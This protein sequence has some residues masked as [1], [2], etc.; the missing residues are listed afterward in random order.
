MNKK[1]GIIFASVCLIFSLAAAVYMIFPKL[2]KCE[3]EKDPDLDGERIE[4]S[5]SNF[6]QMN[7]KPEILQIKDP[8]A[9]D[10]DNVFTKHKA[11]NVSLAIIED[12]YVTGHYE[13][14]YKTLKTKAPMTK[15][16]K[17]RIAS[18]SKIVTTMTAMTLY[19]RGELDLDRDIGDYFGFRIRGYQGHIPITTKMLMS[20]TS[21]LADDKDLERGEALKTVIRKSKSEVPPYVFRYANINIGLVGAE[22][23]MIT[24]KHFQDYAQEALFAPMGLDCG[25]DAAN[26]KDTSDFANLYHRSGALALSADE[27][28]KPRRRRKIGEG[29]LGPFG[30][31]MCSSTELAEVVTVL[32]NNGKYEGREILSEDAVKQMETPVADVGLGFQSC[33]GLRKNEIF[34]REIYYHNGCAYG[35]CSLLAYDKQSRSGVVIITSGTAISQNNG[36]YTACYDAAE[37]VFSEFGVK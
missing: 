3:P 19:D 22:V 8:L 34:D 11:I 20:H 25:Y 13:Y 1:P 26:I 30:N 37:R 2:E 24:E 15:N 27:Q 35:V 14:G 18:L 23:E 33:L 16:T 28:V 21:S 4:V 12:G 7:Q 36:I 32:I 10:L 17:M 9:S 5:D 29:Y 6:N 31:L